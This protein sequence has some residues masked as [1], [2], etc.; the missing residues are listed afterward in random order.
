MALICSICQEVPEEPVLSVVSN[1]VFER[2]L[3]LK[4]LQENGTDPING[5]PLE[6]SQLLEIKSSPLVKPRPPSATSIPAILKLLQDE[7]DSCMLHTFTLR[8]QL[9][10]ARQELSHAL[11]QHDAACRVIARLTKEVNG[12]REALATLKPQA[13]AYMPP[14]ATE[15]PTG[16]E[17]M[18]NTEAGP[19]EMTEE[20]LQQLLETAAML[21]ADRKKRGKKKPE[22]LCTVEEMKTF[23]QKSSHPGLHSSSVPGILALD[24]SADS[25]RVLTGG[26]DKTAIV[27]IKDTEQI[28]ATMKG[29]TKKISSVIYHPKVEL[30]ITGSADS[31]VRVWSIDT[32]VCAQTI[33]AHD[34]GV[35]SV[36]L[37]PTGSY[38]LT[39]STDDYWAFSDITSGHVLTKANSP[40]GPTA[41]TCAQFHPDG[42]IFGTGTASSEVRIWDLKE[43]TNV[44]NFQGHSGAITSIAF[45]ENG[46]YL[47]TGAEDSQVQLWDLRNLKNFETINLGKGYE[48]KNVSFDVSGT[49]LAIAGTDIQVYLCKQWDQLATLKDHT[50]VV[51]GIK[52]GHN[53]S[54]LASC[55]MDRTLR[56]FAPQ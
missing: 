3:I 53:A 29:H 4:Y 32:S 34:G 9:Q 36:S 45:S 8:Q 2:R 16:A 14:G 44:A 42:L 38:L 28:Y 22:G 54:F 33:K 30:A 55:S 7:W 56:F 41:L 37:H 40:S 47:A 5:E 49:Y 15:A 20:I 35:T 12:A 13:A 17:A 43:R 50:S 23:E 24:V 51:N 46:Y 11:Y 52:F 31:T 25:K 48:V 39:S 6:E 18:D 10:T 26:A 27:F 19:T 21:T 1:H